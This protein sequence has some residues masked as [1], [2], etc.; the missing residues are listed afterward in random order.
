MYF[1]AADNLHGYEF[2]NYDNTIGN[3]I[4]VDL[5]VYLEGPFNGTYMGTSLNPSLLPLSQ[6][7]NTTPWNYNG[8]ESVISIPNTDVVDWV[9]VELRDAPDVVSATEATTI[10]KQAAFLLR[11]GSVVGIDGISLIQFSGTI[12]EQLFAVVRNRT[13]VAIISANPLA[14][15]GGVHTYNFTTSIDQVYGGGTGFKSIAIGIYGMAGGDV[16]ADGTVDIADKTLW[17]ITGGSKG[18]VQEDL[19]FDGQVNNLDKDDIWLLNT[20]IISSQVPE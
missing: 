16:D 17:E 3:D 11:D 8:T 5:T 9:V 13:H 12:T 6:P 15:I 4:E 1:N 7:Y 19:N 14:D 10:D 20:N 2:W 18:Y